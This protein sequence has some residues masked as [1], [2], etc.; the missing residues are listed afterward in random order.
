MNIPYLN[1][2]SLIT[3]ELNQ[4]AEE[5]IDISPYRQRW[6]KLNTVSG[7]P[8]HA[9]KLSLLDELMNLP[10]PDHILKTEPATFQEIKA[11]C[12]PSPKEI[13]GLKLSPVEIRDRI[14]GGWFGR[15]A[16]CLLGKPVE[17]IPR[18]GIREILESNGRWPLS[19]YFTEQGLP[20]AIRQKYSW[21]RHGGRDSL[22]ENIVCM[23]EDDDLNYTLL[24]LHVIETYGKDF[25]STNIAETWLS[26][27]PV[28]STFTAERVAYNNCLSGLEPPATAYI[29]NPYREWIGA[30]IRADIWGWISPG[31]PAQAAELAWRDARLSHCGNGIYGE[32]F[33]AA[34]ISATLVVND[35]ET[36]LEIGLC[37]IPEHSRYAR[38]MRQVLTI[39]KTE[40]TWEDIVNRLY[41]QFG[42]YHWVH[43]INNGALVTAALLFGQGDYERSICQAVMGGWDTDC[44]GATVGAIVG[45]MLGAQKLPARWIVPLHNKIRSSVKGF[46]HQTIDEAAFRTVK[47]IIR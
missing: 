7:H 38:A 29:R 6:E 22:K 42:A 1:P 39:T 17:K 27:L 28:L 3:Y 16:G 20:A 12:P 11:Q 19:D 30:Q 41:E 33:F 25:S 37:H 47:K 34:V 45:T 43:S 36:L 23:P 24:N 32:M 18:A 4:R 9:E 15:S 5:G 21:N 46:D 40:K 31:N 44:N 26:M 8:S 13:P 35:P 2:E 10:V 14:A